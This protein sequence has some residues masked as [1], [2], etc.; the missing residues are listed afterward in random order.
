MIGKT[1][2]NKLINRSL[3]LMAIAVFC[4]AP[5][6]MACDVSQ[7]GC[8]ELTSV[9]NGTIL[10]P[11][12]IGPYVA[13][14]GGVGA[15]I[16][17]ICDDF[18]TESFLLSPWAYTT[19]TLSNLSGAKFESQGLA[20]YEKVAWLS[21]QLLYNATSS[22]CNG[23]MGVMTTT[24]AQCQGDIQYAIWSIFDQTAPLPL[25]FLSSI[26]QTNASKLVAAAGGHLSDDFS[27]VTIYTANPLGASQEFIVVRT[28]EPAALAILGVDLCG[29]FGAVLFFLR[30][31]RKAIV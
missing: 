22:W 12:Y 9:G 27:N 21:E 10:G 24:N 15:N 1:M 8:M 3:L 2:E 11:A 14:I 13:T 23:V 7:A 30:R 19:H 17:V 5:S 18:A 25:S 20:S 31:R 29:V 6:A 16:P 28:P 26:D 4:V